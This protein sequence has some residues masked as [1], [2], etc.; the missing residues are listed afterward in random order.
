L[1]TLLWLGVLNK[2]EYEKKDLVAEI[3]GGSEHEINPPILLIY[4]YIKL[5]IKDA[6]KF[7]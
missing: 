2:F 6:I 5:L 3:F 4:Y 7:H 1:Y